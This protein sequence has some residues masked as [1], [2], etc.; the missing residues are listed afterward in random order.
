MLYKNF[1]AELGKLLYAVADIDH[2]ITPE[3]KK[4]LQDIVKNKLVPQDVHTD[5]FGTDTAYY[6][7]MEFDFLDEQIG[8]AV[9]AFESFI[10]F[11]EDHHTA[12]DKQMKNT[13]LR[14]AKELAA[15][16][17]GTSR[18]ERAL[19]EK[20]QKSLRKIKVKD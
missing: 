15:A 1:Y 13:A 12:F 20:L 18:K 3:E 7:E 11:V 9:V 10:D 16:Y 4:K 2:V 5:A 19:L 14:I 8:D 17:E 6:T